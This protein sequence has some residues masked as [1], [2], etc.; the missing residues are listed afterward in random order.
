[1]KLENQVFS[2][3]FT[4]NYRTADI[5]IDSLIDTVEECGFKH[6]LTEDLD[7]A[8]YL[9]FGSVNIRVDRLARNFTL[10]VGSR[11]VTG[12]WETIITHLQDEAWMNYHK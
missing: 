6:T 12:D 10:N 8:I 4:T 11:H 5:V 7:F 1:M 2:E 9:T 3:L